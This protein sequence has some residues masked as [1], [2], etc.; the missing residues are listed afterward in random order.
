M[1]HKLMQ[2]VKHPSQAPLAGPTDW[3]NLPAGHIIQGTN[4][5]AIPFEIIK[6]LLSSES[7]AADGGHV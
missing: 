5:E 1:E 3:A 4:E 7:Q 2:P 6:P